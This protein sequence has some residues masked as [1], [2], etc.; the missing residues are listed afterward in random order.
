MKDLVKE[1]PASAKPKQKELSDLLSQSAWYAELP[2]A[3]KKELLPKLL[4]RRFAAGE[5]LYDQGAAEVGLWCI[6]QGSIHSVGTASDGNR[7]LLSVVRAGDWTGFICIL[8]GR[9]SSF[10]VIAV[11]TVDAVVLPH[12]AAKAIFMQDAARML[13]LG[14]PVATVLRLSFDYLLQS[15]S[16]R[17]QRMVA[18]RLLDLAGSIYQP[19]SAKARALNNCNQDDIAAAVKITRPTANRILKQLAHKGL[20]SLGYGKIE[21]L[22][23][24]GLRQVAQG[25]KNIDGVQSKEKSKGS[26]NARLGLPEPIETI[27]GYDGWFSALPADVRAGLITHMK[28][29]YYGKG[30]TIFKQGGQAKGLYVFLSGQG[31]AIGLA[32][33][34]D[35]VLMALYHPGNW[36]GHAPLVDGRPATMTC[37]AEIASHIGFVSADQVKALFQARP[38]CMA[39]LVA[40]IV[41]MLR[42]IYRHLI[43]SSHAG[44]ER[45]IAERLYGLASIIYGAAQKPRAFVDNFN[46]SDLANATGLSRLTVNKALKKMDELGIVKLGYG[47]ISILNPDA[48]LAMSRGE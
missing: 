43:I 4:R 41:N 22:D 30:E 5:T 2:E 29:E 37:R 42:V 18:Q 14:L 44:P 17:P 46:Q 33:G 21:V 28:I 47:R 12:H 38:E 32:S 19:D 13:L 6:L 15:T 27:L 35:E 16:R 7:T 25:S 23:I 10:S 20:I 3:V 8:D 40:P 48:L 39:A 45:L 11:E 31:R 34:G 26:T 24:T 9:S 36:I 1:Q